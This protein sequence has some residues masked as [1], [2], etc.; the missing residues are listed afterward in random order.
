FRLGGF[1]LPVPGPPT[2]L[3][4]F[5]VLRQYEEGA[6]AEVWRGLCGR[7]APGGL[8]LEGTCSENGRIAG[9]VALEGSGP[10]TL[11]FAARVQAL[12]DPAIFAQRLPKALIHRNVPGEPVHAFLRDWERAWAACAPLGAFG[13]RQRWIGAARLLRA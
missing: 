10:S 6:V 12:E 9:G 8:L 3:R 5:N 11:T 13:A 7:L 4:A 1:E 2:L